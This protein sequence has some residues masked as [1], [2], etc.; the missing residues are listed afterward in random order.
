MS[1][2][3]VTG[4]HLNDTSL[5][6]LPLAPPETI[7]VRGVTE[8]NVLMGSG[9]S[10]TVNLRAN[11]E[12]VGGFTSGIMD[13]VAINGPGAFDNTSTHVNGTATIGVNV[14]GKGTFAINAAHGPGKLEFL[15]SVSAGQTVSVS[16]LQN[17]GPAHDFGVLQVDNPGAYHA[18]N[19]LGYGEIILEGLKATSYSFKND[20]LSIFHGHTIIDTLKL[21]VQTVGAGSPVN[22]GV[23]QVGGSVVVHADGPSY[24]DGGNL[25][26]LHA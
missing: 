13:K 1:T 11:S 10:L 16:G 4:N 14:V 3:N 25:L 24:H 19:V 15:H 17:Y 21:A 6:L 23:S 22:F 20:L 9:D 12:W 8:M 18:S 7:N 26:P 2:H 5:N